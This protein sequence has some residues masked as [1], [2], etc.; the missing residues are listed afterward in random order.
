MGLWGWSKWVRECILFWGIGCCYNES[1]VGFMEAMAMIIGILWLERR[2]L[3]PHYCSFSGHMEAPL[4]RACWQFKLHLQAVN[5]RKRNTVG[6]MW[7]SWHWISLFQQW[8]RS[9]TTSCQK[10]FGQTWFKNHLR[11]NCFDSA[12]I[13]SL[14]CSPCKP[15]Y[16]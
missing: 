11:D 14:F 10:R 9:M 15:W 1:C 6:F 2:I 16:D 8:S 5:E 4:H 3:Y 13:T 12:V 7:L